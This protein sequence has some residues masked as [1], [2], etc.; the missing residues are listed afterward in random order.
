MFRSVFDPEY[1]DSLADIAKDTIARKNPFPSL[2]G[3]PTGEYACKWGLTDLY[4]ECEKILRDAIENRKTFD[5]GWVGC[6]KEIRSFRM[7]SDGKVL[8]IQ[9]SA[10]MDEF[11]DLIYDA[12]ETEE[13]VTDEQVEELHDYWYESLD[14]DTDAG[15]EMTI[16]LTTYE[17]AMELMSKM[18]DSDEAQLA[19]WF[20]V[21]KT[22]VKEVTS[23]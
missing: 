21:V 16:P 22:W 8:T 2:P 17:D 6:K 18:E 20:E 15:S 14:M 3:F 12:M 10:S 13:E 7:I 19:E 11:D 9:T 5:T 23:R 4:P 1:I